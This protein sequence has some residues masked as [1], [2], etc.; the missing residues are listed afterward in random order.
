MKKLSSLVWL[1]ICS[2]SAILTI[3][4]MVG[5]TKIIK[6]PKKIDFAIF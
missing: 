1:L 2:A 3:I 4:V 6:I 5:I